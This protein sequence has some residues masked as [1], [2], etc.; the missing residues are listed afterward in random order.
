[1]KTLFIGFKSTGS[2]ARS[3]R[4]GVLASSLA[5]VALLAAP[6]AIE[7]GSNG[8]S[9]LI[10][11]AEAAKGGIPGPPDDGGGGGEAP[12]FGDLIILYR[13]LSGV[14]YLTAD[15]CQQPLPSDTCDTTACV[16]VPGVPAGADVI[17]VDP[18]TCAVTTAACATCTEEVDFGR[19][20]E[21]R[22]P[23][24]VFD[25]Q[26]ADVIVN[27]ATADCRTLDPAGRLVATRVG[28]DLSVL[29]STIDSPLQN[30]AIYRQLILTGTL[31]APLPEGAGTLDTA[32]RGLGAASD[33]AGEVNVDLVAYLNFIMG[34]SDPATSTILDPKTCID[35][36]EEVQ[37]DV[38]M[39]NKCFLDYGAYGYHR[40]TNFGALPAP[41]YIPE[42]APVAGTLEY[43]SLVP[44]TDPPLFEI[45]YDL[46][47]TA[48]FAD[49]AGDT[50]GNIGG[51]AQASDDTRAVISFMHE[52]QVP[53]DFETAVPCEPTPGDIAYDVLISDVSGLQVPKNIVDGSEG[54]EFVVTV[55]NASGSADP[56]S[57]TVTVTA[58]PE[59]GGN[60]EG[61]PWT[62]CFDEDA[63]NCPPDSE[64]RPALDVGASESWTT[65]FTVDL[66][67][68]TTINWT[69]V[70]V[71]EFDV[72]PANNIVTAVSNVKVTGGGRR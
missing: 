37:G 53:V 18:A 1:M 60:I 65:F 14:P 66:G 2:D 69:A 36:K 19:V 56:A 68:R 24:A 28:D 44:D 31:G 32:A 59:S 43:L 15:S 38:V 27:L 26:L 58:I 41:P 46:I 35:V 42:S 11:S 40:G 48:V 9:G 57:G 63:A 50:G 70:A 30:L 5:A 21:A 8:A 61:S 20:N 22:S 71:A 34:L 54:R 4:W 10:G 3:T 55:A 45:L 13:D 64:P 25:A 49:E 12:D 51:F 72:N 67:Q 33:K 16:L 47:T 6:L 52:N 62:F 29:V 7:I 23:D 17:P 39:V